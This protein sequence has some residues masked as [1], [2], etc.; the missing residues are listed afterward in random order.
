MSLISRDKVAKD[1]RKR[2]EKHVEA[3]GGSVAIVE[4]SL[5]VRLTVEAVSKQAAESGGPG[6]VYA[7]APHVLAGCVLDADGEPLMSVDEWQVFGSRHRNEAVDLCNVAMRLS[8]FSGEDA[9]KN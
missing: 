8:G 3:L 9:E 5:T 4:M 1:P 2:E 7:T 6:A